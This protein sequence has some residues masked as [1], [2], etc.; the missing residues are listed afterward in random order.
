[1]QPTTS[2][3]AL[4][5]LQGFTSQRKSPVDILNESQKTLGVPDSQQR[6]VGLRGAVTNT[7]NLLRG[8]DPSVTGRTQ[9]SLVTDAQRQRLV[10][11]ERAPLDQ[12]FQTQ[13]GALAN[14]TANANTLNQ[15]AITQAQLSISGEDQKQNALKSI[16]DLLFGQ[17][18][19]A[20][21]KRRYEQARADQLAR[22]KA[23]RA[24]QAAQ[25]NYIASLLASQ[26]AANAPK[27]TGLDG[28]FGN[29][30]SLTSV[31]TSGV[32]YQSGNT[33][34]MPSGLSLLSGSPTNNRTV[35]L[36][37]IGRTVD[38]AS[39]AKKTPTISSP[40]NLLRGF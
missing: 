29:G 20:E 10:A 9:G 14:E 25:D 32:T 19:N 8:V 12:A 3:E 31:P 5:Q 27:S 26:N 18:Q 4:T 28:I 38:L 1:M 37:S 22:D 33:F 30:S 13:Q 35:D 23:S 11:M 39:V 21:A 24:A 6:V 17:E 15:N 40:F 34:G 2:Q 16:Y 7:E 36:S